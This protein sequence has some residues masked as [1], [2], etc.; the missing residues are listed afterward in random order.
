MGT[1]NSPPSPPPIETEEVTHHPE[2]YIVEFVGPYSFKIPDITDEDIPGYEVNLDEVKAE[3]RT[4]SSVGGRSAFKGGPATFPRDRHGML[5]NQEIQVHFSESYINSLP[6]DIEEPTY[7]DM[8]MSSRVV[9]LH[10]RLTDD[11][12]RFY[13]RFLECYK[14]TTDNYWMRGVNVNEIFNFTIKKIE[15]GEVAD[16]T[17]LGITGGLIDSGP[18]SEQQD[19]ALRH[20]LQEGNELTVSQQLHLDILDKMDLGEYTIAVIN[21]KQL[22]EFWTRREFKRIFVSQG[23]TVEEAEEQMWNS[24]WDQ[25]DDVKTI[26]QMIKSEGIDLTDSTELKLWERH[27]KDLRDEIV[28][29]GRRA[30]EIDA[31]YAYHYTTKAMRVFKAKFAETFGED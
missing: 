2:K 7:E 14:A 1:D 22:F 28:H 3:I 16:E 19:K 18:I 5:M 13:N 23:K 4:G 9:G 8:M 25:Y 6:S 24:D 29:E 20:H 26:Y 17:G 21:S 12:I 27:C 10:K 30:T 15:D 31:I 11:A